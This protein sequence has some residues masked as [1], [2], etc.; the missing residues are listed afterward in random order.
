LLAVLLFAAHSSLA[1]AQTTAPKPPAPAP[2]SPKPT[3]KPQAVDSSAMLQRLDEAWTGDLDGMVKRRRIRVILPYSKTSYFIDKGVQRG[4]AYDFFTMFEDSLNKKLKTGNLRVHVTFIP[5]SRDQLA[6]ALLTGKGDI[7][8]GNLT[9]TDARREMADFSEP[10]G[11][12]VSEILVAGPGS[13]AVAT[14]DDLAGQTVHVRAGSNYYDDLKALSDRMAQQGKKAIAI[15]TLPGNLEDEDILEMVNAG[16]VKMTVVDDHVASFWKQ[17]LPKLSVRSDL[18]IKSDQ[19]VGYAM[20]KGSPQLK[21]ELDAFVKTHKRGTAAGNVVLT[22]YLKN[23]KFARSATGEAE[24][25]R[26]NNLIAL[27]RKYGDQYGVD[28]VL[29]AAQGFQ[30]SGLNQ[31]AH[32][33]VGAVGVMQVMPDTGKDMKV[34]DIKLVEPNINAGVKYVRFMIDQYY[35]DEPMDD[36]NKGLFAFASYNAGPGRVKQ[37]RREAQQSG[38]DPNVWFNNVERIASKRVGRETVQYVSNIYKYYVAYTLSLEEVAERQ[39]T[40]PTGRN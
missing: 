24:L 22:K 35:K 6:N 19:E 27:F 26:F 30:E 36:L 5:T 16:L 29:L 15:K 11:D 4:I 21:A 10:V 3:A 23:T 40:R 1:L 31:D 38:L 9:I 34:G 13:P 18:V 12:H 8:A 33:K 7:A 20:R 32:S 28:W 39:R 2:Q 25:K 17:I 37:L 14:L